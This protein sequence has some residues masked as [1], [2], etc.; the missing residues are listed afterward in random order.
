[1]PTKLARPCR[2]PGCPGL[3]DSKEGYC[4]LHRNAGRKVRSMDYLKKPQDKF[5]SSDAWARCRMMKLARDPLCQACMAE[6]RL[7]PGQIVH[8]VKPYQDRPD[9]AYHL[10]NLETLCRSCHAREHSYQ[11]NFKTT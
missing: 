1:M 7:V 10:D 11:E 3:T 5:Y 2:H 8:H 9:L 4:E 6:G